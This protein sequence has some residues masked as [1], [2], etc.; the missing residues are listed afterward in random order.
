MS[1]WLLR[2]LQPISPLQLEAELLSL[3][4]LLT[5]GSPL[6]LPSTGAAS[7]LALTPASQLYYDADSGG[8]SR[9][10]LGAFVVLR[11]RR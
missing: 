2:L 5:G 3:K 7:D 9:S 6:L 1:K 8:H 10:E 11:R 4:R